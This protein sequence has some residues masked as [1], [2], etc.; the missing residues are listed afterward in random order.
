MNKDYTGLDYLKLPNELLFKLNNITRNDLLI[1]TVFFLLIWYFFSKLSLSISTLLCFF[2]SILITYY[3]IENIY[4]K[5]NKK[6]IK[7]KKEVNNFNISQYKYL[8]VDPIIIKIYND[9]QIIK[10]YN[11]TS[12]HNSLYYIN[13][14]LK[15]YKKIKTIFSNEDKIDTIIQ[16]VIYQKITNTIIYRKKALNSLMSI[17][18][19]IPNSEVVTSEYKQ[20]IP[21][22]KYI[23]T[24]TKDLDIIS[25]NKLME[26]IKLNNKLLKTKNINIYSNFIRVNEPEP[27][28]LNEKDYSP[29]FNLY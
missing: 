29:N 9:I 18:C 28:P 21:L 11:E 12:F 20:N 8:F 23:E 13:K 6:E 2:I 17:I 22:Q 7:L 10:K 19:S 25:N 16:Q 14:F 5:K 15:Y 1:V 4:N 24:K 3:V 26:L 27:N